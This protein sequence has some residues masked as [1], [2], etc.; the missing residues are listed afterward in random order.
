MPRLGVDG[1][2]GSGCVSMVGNL[3][4]LSG[5]G[6]VGAA[7]LSSAALDA[8]S[9]D[10]RLDRQGYA[11]RGTCTWVRCCSVGSE[12]DLL[13]TGGRS[14]SLCLR[15]ACPWRLYDENS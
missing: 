14:V 9:N 6:G 11:R 1:R 7:L 12:L 10:T 8:M 15:G 5:A 13:H 2:L 3:K 4:M